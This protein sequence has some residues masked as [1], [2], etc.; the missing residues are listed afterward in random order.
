MVLHV[1]DLFHLVLRVM[2][3]PA[4]SELGGGALRLEAIASRMAVITT[5]NKKLLVK[6]PSKSK[7]QMISASAS[8]RA[9]GG[10]S[11]K[12]REHTHIYIYMSY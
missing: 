7:N 3:C 8:S 11:L 12:K 9:A 10:A 6:F 1:G 2:L 5:S 4:P